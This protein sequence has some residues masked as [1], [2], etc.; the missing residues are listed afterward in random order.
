MR[1]TVTLDSDVEET[2]R[3]EMRSGKGKSF[4][5]ALNDLIRRAR[6]SKKDKIKTAKPFTIRSKNMGTYPHINYDKTSE[7]ISILDEEECR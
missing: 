2:I 3:E 1:T 5:H 6:Y 7:L 4:K